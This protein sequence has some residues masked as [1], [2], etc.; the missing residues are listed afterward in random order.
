MGLKEIMKL[1]D[2]LKSST[3]PKD[4]VKYGSCISKICKFQNSAYSQ[5]RAILRQFPETKVYYN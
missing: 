4:V 2:K 5:Y 1:F 3:N